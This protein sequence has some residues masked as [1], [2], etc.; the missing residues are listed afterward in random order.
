M[1]QVFGAL[2]ADDRAT[3]ARLLQ[4]LDEAMAPLINGDPLITGDP[5]TEE[6]SFHG[7][8]TR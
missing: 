8:I 6:V 4:T 1:K 5:H 3:M 2:Q 7:R